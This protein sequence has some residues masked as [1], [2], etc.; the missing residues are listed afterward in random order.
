MANIDLMKT[1]A[2][3]TLVL[4]FA[5]RVNAQEIGI[6]PTK[7][8]T[9]NKEIGNP[10]GF[11]VHL[12]QPIWKIGLKLEYSFARN[13]RS[14]YG[15]L[16]SGFMM[17]PSQYSPEPILSQSSFWSVELSLIIPRIVAYQ[18][19]AMNVGGGGSVNRFKGERLGTLSKRKVSLFREDKFGVFYAISVSREKVF[20]VPLKL[21]VL[22]KH[23]NLMGSVYATDI[24]QSFEGSMDMKEIQFNISYVF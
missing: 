11:S 17:Y 19:F 15:I 7:I 22:F 1:V 5:G 24:E 18:E 3:W 4:I 23:K 21:E 9:D 12:F 6:A 14:Y 13:E 16:V 10:I 8:W 2:C 20:G